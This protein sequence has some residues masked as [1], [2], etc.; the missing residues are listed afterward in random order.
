MP[1]NNPIYALVDV[2]R[3]RPREHELIQVFMTEAG[4][5][6]GL[7]DRVAG[8]VNDEEW[9]IQ[10]LQVQTW[11]WEMLKNY[12]R[13]RATTAPGLSTIACPLCGCACGMGS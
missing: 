6:R 10:E 1:E 8:L 3:K 5:L 11:T 12:N 13:R 9:D 4:A 7:V 2:R